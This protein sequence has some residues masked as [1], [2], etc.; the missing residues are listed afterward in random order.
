MAKITI[1]T[2]STGDTLTASEWEDLMD[3]VRD[4]TVSIDTLSILL[5]GTEVTASAAE[6]NLLDGLTSSTAELNLLDGLTATTTE[7]NYS[8]GVT[9]DIQTQL[10]TKI[11]ESSTDTLTNKTI[12][13]ASNT[14]TIVEADISDLGTY[15]ANVVEDTTPQLGGDLDANGNDLLNL[16][17]AGFVH[18]S[19]ILS[20]G[21]DTVDWTTGNGQYINL[22]S[23][24]AIT[25]T[26]TAPPDDTRLQLHITYGTGANSITWPATVKWPGGT[27][28]TL[29][30]TDAAIDIATFWY[31]GTNYHGV[32]SQDF[33]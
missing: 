16:V 3:A 23:N 11:T 22:G 29:T 24:A 26:F 27:A 28:P 8:S 1:P 31:D 19:T 6:M 14:I 25:L 7:L 15:L 21:T 12:N 13:T 33:S 10:N 32:I 18:P 20:D 2:K 9:S 30:G 4:G 17:V 5:G